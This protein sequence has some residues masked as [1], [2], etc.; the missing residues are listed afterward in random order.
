MRFFLL[1]LLFIFP[2]AKALAYQVSF[3]G[4]VPS[5]VMETIEAISKLKADAE[6]PP[7][8]LFT[9][10]KRAE[11]DKNSMINALHAFGFYEGSVAVSYLG[12]FPNTTVRLFISPGPTYTFA[13]PCIFDEEGAPLN[14]PLGRLSIAEG[15]Q[16]RSDR[17]LD[18]EEEILSAVQTFGYPYPFLTNREVVVD[19]ESKQVA[20]SFWIATGPCAVFGPVEVE[21]LRKVRRRVVTRRVAWK[22]GELYQ[23]EKVRCTDTFLQESGL[24]SFVTVRPGGE[25]NENG[26]LPMLIKVEEKKYRHIGAG[27]S[28]S[29]DESAGVMAQWSHDN[30]SGWG[31]ALAFVGEYSEVIKR[32]TLL[33]GMPDFFG[34]NQDLLYSAEIRREDAPGFTEKEASFLIRVSRKVNNVF[35]FNYGARFE[36]LLSTKS[37]NDENYNLVSLPIQV[38]FDTSNRLLNPNRG[39][40]IA[41]FF[42]PYQALFNNETAFLRE[43]VFAAAYQTLTPKGGI[44]MALSAQIGSIL[45]PSTFYIPAPKRFYAGSSTGLRGYKYLTVS[46][47]DE[48]TPIGGRSLMIFQIEPR[49]RVYKKVYLATFYDIGNVYSPPFPKLNEKLLRSIGCGI[50]YLTPLGPFRVDVGFPLDKRKG[51]DKSFQIYASIGQTF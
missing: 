51:I 40:T 33:Y 16:A 27:V 34:R 23:P 15:C 22:T 7:P 3:E 5:E 9:L 14:L 48:T 32:A 1:L 45:G 21:G 2:L 43:E 49:F 39:V 18:A 12:E 19:Q 42:T 35:S 38:R 31:D 41:Y 13:S 6:R 44:I 4:D 20:A 8:S 50:R 29:T 28:Y 37:N 11:T 36:K 10:K 46:P 25:V 30:F 26:Q 24:F 47:L 17:I